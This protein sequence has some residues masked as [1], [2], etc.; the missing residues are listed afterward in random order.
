MHWAGAI[1][2][3]TREP[4]THA[5]RQRRGSPTRVASGPRTAAASPGPRAR[6]GRTTASVTARYVAGPKATYRLACEQQVRRWACWDAQRPFLHPQPGGQAAPCEKKSAPSTTSAAR[7]PPRRRGRSNPRW[8]RSTSD[9]HVIRRPMP[10]RMRA[11]ACRSEATPSPIA[12]SVYA[13]DPC[14]RRCG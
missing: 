14:R 11:R 6:H 1:R 9:E 13:T 4:T 10:E 8:L 12:P 5:P 3:Q 7:G 2:S